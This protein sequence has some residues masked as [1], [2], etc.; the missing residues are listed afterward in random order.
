[1]PKSKGGYDSRRPI[2]RPTGYLRIV[3]VVVVALVMS[4]TAWQRQQQQPGPKPDA[5]RPAEQQQKPPATTSRSDEEPEPTS[6]VAPAAIAAKTVIPN[7]TILDQTGKAVYRGDI[8]LG[9]TLQRIKD[10]RR[11]SFS[12][13]G[14][15]FENRERRLPKQPAAY[16]KEYVH[17]TPGLAGPGPQ[18]IVMGQEGEAWYTPDHYRTFR[19]VAP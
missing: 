15:T 5:P 14:A 12:H 16:Y 9:P 1:M 11:L 6:A 3:I 2:W 17:P 18:R 7:Q 13:D 4:Y 10:G 8:D 19:Q